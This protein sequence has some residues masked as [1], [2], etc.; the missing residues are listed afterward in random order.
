MTRALTAETAVGLPGRWR[1]Y[2]TIEERPVVV[3]LAQ[4]ATLPRA[5]AP[6]VDIGVI[7]TARRRWGGPRLRPELGC[8]Q[9]HS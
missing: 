4:A 1:W 6:A 7:S 2:V 8:P 3:I 9:D 5:S